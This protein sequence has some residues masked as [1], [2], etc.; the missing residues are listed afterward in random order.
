MKKEEIFEIIDKFN[1]SNLSK[2]K[3]SKNNFELELKKECTNNF[4]TNVTSENYTQDLNSFNNTNIIEEENTSTNNFLLKS[5]LVATFYEAS[6][7]ESK[8]FIKEGDIVK[9]GDILF[10]LEAMKMINE[11]KSPVSGKIINIFPK[12][13]ELVEYNQ[14]IL[15]IE[16]I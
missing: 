8:P 7:P 15:E 9:E 3:L 6:S 5:P 13:G 11:I 12:N 2:L 10:I 16:E 1:S 14:V 4:H